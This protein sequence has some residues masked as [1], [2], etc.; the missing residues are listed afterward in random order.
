MLTFLVRIASGQ[1]RAASDSLAIEHVTIVDVRAGTLVPDQTVLVA[2]GRIAAIGRSTSGRPSRGVRVVDGRA[3]FLIPGL[4]DMHD[5]SAASGEASRRVLIPLLVAN[6][7]IGVREMFGG[8]AELALRDDIRRG[9]VVG[10]RMIVGSPI[11]D[12]PRPMWD[13]SISIATEA[14]G[15]TAVDS[16]AV[17]GYDFIKIY[18]FLPLDAFRG[19]ADEAK[20]KRIALSGHVPFTVNAGDASDAGL[21]SLEHAMGIAL[22]CSTN[23][24]EIRG[25]L[26]DAAANVPAAFPPHAALLTRGEDQPLSTFSADKC[27]ALFARLVKNETWVVPTLALHRAHANGTDSTTRHDP[28]LQYMPASVRAGWESAMAGRPAPAGAA[29]RRIDPAVHRLTLAMQKAGVSL[30]AGT[31]A[32]NPFV[33]PGFSLHDELA[34]LVEA[35]LT[36]LEAL[37]S[38]TIAPAM[39]L[40]ATDSLGTIDQGRVADLVLLDANPLA[41]IHNTTRIR[42][43]VLAGRLLERA[44]LDSLLAAAK[45]E[46]AKR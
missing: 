30:L 9:A 32:M 23:E 28:R 35:G 4:W 12:G 17:A 22:A 37:R 26:V 29:F 20:Q 27:G 10:P 46:A 43:V 34:L 31:D 15:R 24:A 6:G 1:S 39:F 3:G 7:I 21:R 25:G 38:A 11:L 18:Q 33:I 41:D 45:G 13:G 36:P 16:L 5:H 42:A 14:A 19:I 40:H 8:R 44:A 2:G